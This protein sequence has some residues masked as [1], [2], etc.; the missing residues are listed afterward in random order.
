MRTRDAQPTLP[1]AWLGLGLGLGLGLELGL[2][3]GLGFA[4][5][6]ARAAC[7]RKGALRR[8]FVGSGRKAAAEEGGRGE[9]CVGSAGESARLRFRV[10]PRISLHS[11]LVSRFAA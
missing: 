5:E 11:A 3:P 2:G 6:D 10:T 8:C 9:G 1:T 4:R 7:V